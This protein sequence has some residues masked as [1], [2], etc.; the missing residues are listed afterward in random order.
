MRENGIILTVPPSLVSVYCQTKCTSNGE[1][2]VISNKLTQ[3]VNPDRSIVQPYA[4]NIHIPSI[5]SVDRT[6]N[7]LLFEV[8]DK[9]GRNL[10]KHFWVPNSGLMYYYKLNVN[11]SD[12]I[13]SVVNGPTLH[14]N[15][16]FNYFHIE[17][18]RLGALCTGRI[19]DENL[20]IPYKIEYNEEGDLQDNQ[21]GIEIHFNIDD[22]S[23]F[24]VLN[25]AGILT[26]LGITYFEHL[27]AYKMFI[28][29]YNSESHDI[30]DVPSECAGPHD[31][32]PVGQ[33]DAVIKCANG[34]VLYFNGWYSTFTTLAHSNIEIVSTCANTTSFVLVPSIGNIIFNKSGIIYHL[35]MNTSGQSLRIASAVCHAFGDEITYYFA[36]ATN[37]AIYELYL[38]DIVTSSSRQAMLPKVVRNDIPRNGKISLY[39]NG[40]ILWAKFNS[41]DDVVVY[42]TEL[43]TE[44][45]SLPVQA[46]GPNVF[47]EL[48][49]AE[50]CEQVTVSPPNPP[51]GKQ[52]NPNDQTTDDMGL[53]VLISSLLG[54]AIVII[55]III[56][57]VVFIVYRH[58]K[59]SHMSV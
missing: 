25:N 57:L 31:L 45:Q 7:S 37:G 36:D 38:G 50:K 56:L 1:Y 18:R 13:P 27:S 8:Q 12:T 44:K 32:Q 59:A 58:K 11:V 40:P 17:N 34:K 26:V 23:P 24:I 43:L 9:E 52:Q 51:T 3:I 30:I 33:S 16:C 46:N 53:Y 21:L 28:I 55:I 42:I 19:Y 41:S 10:E 22:H 4:P 14:G 35:P 48:F 2:A 47:V 5:C 39:I 29:H 15:Y 54:V 6:C 20:I 49:T